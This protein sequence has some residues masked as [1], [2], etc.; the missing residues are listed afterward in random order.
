MKPG[1]SKSENHRHES[2]ERLAQEADAL[3]AARSEDC[4]EFERSI[5]LLKNAPA[6]NYDLSWR[7]SR[8]CFFL[9]QQT[10]SR[11]SAI[12]THFLGIKA[13]RQAIRQ[14]GEGVEGYFWLGVNL[15][16]LAERESSFAAFRAAI[17]AYRA[18]KRAIN[19][20][21][22]YHGAGPLRVLARLQHKLPK[23]LGGGTAVAEANYQAALASDPD[24]TVSRIYFA[25][26]LVETGRIQEA[27]EQLEAALRVP[28]NPD[29][30][31]EINRDRALATEML[32]KLS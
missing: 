22:T 17:R 5:E 27:K 14:Q 3:Y 10:K 11:D 2:L 20:D 18:L 19:L 21:R 32:A 6:A 9:G 26:L 16:L 23:V 28:T 8:A 30:S 25:E 13:G 1:N 4:V 31:F 29:W 12:E 24:N 15:A 7:L